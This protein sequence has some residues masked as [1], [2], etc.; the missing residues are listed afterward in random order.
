M[1]TDGSQSACSRCDLGSYDD[2]T[3]QVVKFECMDGMPPPDKA[4]NW[5]QNGGSQ[6]EQ[7]IE[8]I[9]NYLKAGMA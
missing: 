1:S 8:A 2:D 9:M 6:G 7:D 4:A 5:A 3:T